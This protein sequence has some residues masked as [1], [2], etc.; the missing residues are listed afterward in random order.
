[1]S[2][3]YSS[4]APNLLRKLSELQAACRK[5]GVTWPVR[6]RVGIGKL[7]L[8]THT[9][10]EPLKAAL[11]EKLEVVA[12]APLQLPQVGSGQ[13]AIANNRCLSHTYT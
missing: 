12:A 5:T 10:E 1:M 11:R 13:A 9:P 2:R 4:P 7:R 6:A 8:R 3:G